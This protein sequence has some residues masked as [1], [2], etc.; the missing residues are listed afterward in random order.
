[1]AETESGLWYTGDGWKENFPRVVKGTPIDVTGA[2]ETSEASSADT[3]HVEED[4][5]PEDQAELD[6]FKRQLEDFGN[7]P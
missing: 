1:M 6:E 3:V 4:L 7:K 5:T 2:P